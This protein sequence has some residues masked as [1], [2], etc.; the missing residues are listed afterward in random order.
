TL[1]WTVLLAAIATT[2]LLLAL[3]VVPD[4][5]LLS[6]GI[7]PPIRVSP[8]QWSLFANLIGYL[9]I[10][11]FFLCEYAWRQ[12]RFPQQPYRNFFDFLRRTIAASPRLLTVQRPE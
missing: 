7:T 5:L 9:L 3:L 4:G 11:A 12:H 2:N 8:T 1:A 10:A 6:A